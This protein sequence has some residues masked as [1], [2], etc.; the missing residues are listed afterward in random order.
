MLG[1]DPTPE[2]EALREMVHKFAAQRD[3]A[4]GGGVGP[5]RCLPLELFRKAFDLG[6]MTGFIPESYGGQG[7]TMFETCI[8]EEEISW[9]ARRRH[10]R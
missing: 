10:V 2:Q 7:L 4:A 6:L 3:P 9:G 5:G 8:L 1:F